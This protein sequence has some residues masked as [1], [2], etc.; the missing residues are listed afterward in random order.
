MRI[1][2]NEFAKMRHLRVGLLALVLLSGVV[3]LTAFRGLAS[4]MANDLSD[5][6]GFAWKILLAGLGFS[7]GLISPLIIAA[8]ASRQVE[9]E[10]SG[11]G[12]LLSETS[13]VTPG[14]LC[15]AK[16]AALGV[17]V[18][19]S[20]LAQSL[21]LVAIGFGVGI[22]SPVPVE[23]WLGYTTAVAVVNLA[24]LAVHLLLS[25]LIENQL[26][27]MGIAVIGLFIAVF[28]SALPEWLAM[29]TPWGYYSLVAPAD[30]V[31]TDLVY[32]DIPYLSVLA[33]GLAGA[34]LFTLITARFDRREA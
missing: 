28:A 4:G 10:H 30:Y 8:I 16:F 34:G 21:I 25:A 24:V 5:P 3:G 6:A 33:L 31:G 14:R 27:C 2:A 26:V 15:R 13:G 12:W 1:V 17:L 22:A 29:L 9:A 18:T 11:N 32:L 23:Q 20:T 19:T 7:A